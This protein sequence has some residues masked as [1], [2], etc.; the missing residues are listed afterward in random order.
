MKIYSDR[1]DELL[2]SLTKAVPILPKTST[3]TCAEPL[4]SIAESLLPRVSKPVLP[5]V[6]APATAQ[7]SL[8]TS[9]AVTVS[10]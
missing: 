2:S 5:P 9:P 4:V 6:S 7:S 8:S 3:A 1:R 10:A